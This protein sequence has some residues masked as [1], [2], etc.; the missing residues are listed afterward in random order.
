MEQAHNGYAADQKITCRLKCK[1][2]RVEAFVRRQNSAVSAEIVPLLQGGK[3]KKRGAYQPSE[4]LKRLRIE[5]VINSTIR[6]AEAEGYLAI[7][8][9]KTN[10]SFLIK[11]SW[12]QVYMMC[13]YGEVPEE[14][15]G[16]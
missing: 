15:M 4:K 13:A 7:E 3:G 2:R 8:D 11:S 14:W 6:N 16:E 12:K 10:S 1:R 9:T 5:K